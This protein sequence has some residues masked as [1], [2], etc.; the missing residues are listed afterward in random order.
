MLKPLF[1]ST[2]WGFA[3]FLTF[4]PGETGRGANTA[5]WCGLA[6]LFWWCDREKG[7]AGMLGECRRSG[8]ASICFTETNQRARSSLLATPRSFRRGSR[9]RRQ[10]TTGWSECVYMLSASF[11]EMKSMACC[12]EPYLSFQTCRPPPR[13]ASAKSRC[14][15]RNMHICGI[16]VQHRQSERCPR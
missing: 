5:W 14:C 7:V 9:R 6:N 16:P 12:T 13:N 2:G 11:C 4:A 8:C 3:H 10:S 1:T 15:P